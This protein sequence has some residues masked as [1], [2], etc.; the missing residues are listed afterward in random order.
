MLRSLCL[1]VAAG[2][3]CIVTS[4]TAFGQEV[5]LKAACGFDVGSA[6]C[7]SFERYVEFV[8]AEGKGVVKINYIGGGPKLM[9]IFEM[10]NALKTGVF[11]ILNTN[12]TFY[13]NLMP[14]ADAIKLARKTVGEMRKDGSWDYL[15]RIQ[16][17]KMNAHMIA[18]SK[19]DVPAHFYLRKGAKLPTGIDF[20]GMKLRS[21]PIYQPF[22]IAL[23]ATPVRMVPAD[24]YTGMERNVVDGY[25]WPLHGIDELGL[26]PVTAYRIDPGFYVV[27]GEILINLDVWKKLGPRQK[28]VLE[29]GG[30]WLESWLPMYEARESEK[31]KAI[32]AAAGIKVIELK[33]DEAKRFL[34]T[35]YK[36]GWEAVGKANPGEGTKLRS[37]VDGRS[38]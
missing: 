8:N 38:N 32:Q 9:S 33:P 14:E 15:Q 22:L 27:T 37:A 23:G 17:Q 25:G 20:T 18:R 12:N 1:R 19:G 6:Y 2:S 35:A 4:L 31:A 16:N 34:E 30:R 36:V 3:A 11:D 13:T 7:R 29:F 24:I 5:Q 10:G 28:E 21:T 26:L